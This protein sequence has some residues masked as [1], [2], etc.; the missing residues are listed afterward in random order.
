LINQV[1]DKDSTRSVDNF[2]IGGAKIS[3]WKDTTTA[4]KSDDETYTTRLD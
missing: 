1:I 4:T 3:A 2:D